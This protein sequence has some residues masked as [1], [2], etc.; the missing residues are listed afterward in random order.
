[1]ASK[2]K[3]GGGC[4]TGAVAQEEEIFRRTSAFMTH[5]EEWYPLEPEQV[6]FSPQVHIVKDSDYK[7]L[8]KGDVVSIGMLAVHAIKNPTLTNR[9]FSK[10]DWELTEMKIESI[11]KI[12][13]INGFDSLVLGAL[14][15]G[16]YGNP[17][18]EVLK[19]FQSMVKKYDKCFNK[20]GFAVLVLG[21]NG[22]N[23]FDLFRN[24]LS[25]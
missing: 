7:L 25:N 11:F 20:I 17:A 10:K 5:P 12:A 14:G 3:P 8:D 19:I 4:R 1:M 13:L 6:V 18:T 24:G 15:C 21:K 9:K 23:N 2:F 22:Q 16:A